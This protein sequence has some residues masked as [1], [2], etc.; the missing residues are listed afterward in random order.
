MSSV[1]CCILLLPLVF[2]VVLFLMWLLY[3]EWQFGTVVAHW[4]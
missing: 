3:Y 1:T 2:I 4:S